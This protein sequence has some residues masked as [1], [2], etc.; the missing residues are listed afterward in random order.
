MNK[1]KFRQYIELVQEQAEAG[2]LGALVQLNHII[3]QARS[4]TDDLLIRSRAGDLEALRELNAVLADLEQSHRV[5]T[6]ALP[7]N[8]RINDVPF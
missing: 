5:A 8:I 2:D 6:R 1:F 4:Y 3:D 7:N